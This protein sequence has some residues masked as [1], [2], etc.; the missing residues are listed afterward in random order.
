MDKQWMTVTEAA[1]FV[2]KSKALIAKMVREGGLVSDKLLGRTVVSR[3]SLKAYKRHPPRPGRPPT[4]PRCPHCERTVPTQRD[5]QQH[6]ARCRKNPH[7]RKMEEC[8]HCGGSFTKGM[9]FR[10]HVE[11]CAKRQ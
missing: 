3:E 11:A 1:E 10:R 7:K 5:L 6:M 9:P 4:N 2:G 8:P